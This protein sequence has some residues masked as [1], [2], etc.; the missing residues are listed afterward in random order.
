MIG[1]T[2]SHYKILEKLGEGGMGIVYKAQDTKLDRVVA[3]KFLPQQTSASE[4]DK[5]RFLQEAK[6]AAAL[7]HPNICTIHGIEEVQ[8]NAFIVM[9]FVEGRTL[10]EQTEQSPLKVKEA[11]DIAVKIAQGLTAAHEKGIVHR[12]M[13]SAN[14]M[15]TDNMDVKIMDF[16][17]A[18]IA[19]GSALLTKQG[20]TLGTIAYMSPE[21]ARGEKTDRR[22]DVWSLGV[23]LYEIVTGRLPFKGEFEQAV[24][25][26]LLNEEP[27]PVTAVRSGVPLGLERVI[28]KAMA[29]DPDSRYQHADEIIVDLKSVRSSS[30][31]STQA[32]KVSTSFNGHPPAQN[33]RWTLSPLWSGVL[34]AT[35]LLMGGGLTWLAIPKTSPRPLPVT[36]FVLPFD[37]TSPADGVTSFAISP[38]GSRLAYMTRRGSS[39]ELFIREMDKLEARPVSSVKGLTRTQL[40]FSPDSRW[41]GFFSQGKMNKL[42]LGGGAPIIICDAPS[43]SSATWGEGGSIVFHREW[44]SHLWIV[45]SEANST[46]RQLTTLK[47]E[48]GERGHLGASMLPGGTHALFTIWTGGALEDALIAA[49]EL[50]TGKHQVIV[51]GGADAHYVPS[52][53]LVYSRGATLMAVPFNLSSMKTTGETLPVMDNVRFAGDAGFSSMSISDNGTVAY[54]AGGVTYS[55]TSVG[56]FEAGKKTRDITLSGKNFG[57]PF[58]SPDGKKMGLVLFADTYHLSLYDLQKQTLT[59]LTFS[60]DN[61]RPTWLR[62]GSKIAYS[63]NLGGKYTVYTINADGSGT[64]E[65]LF[66]QEG[67]PYPVSWSPDG[68]TLAYVTTGK[69][70]KDDIWFYSREGEPKLRPF[71][72][73]SATENS[74]RISPDGRWIAYVSNES[75][76]E[77]VYVKRYPSGDGKWRISNGRGGLPRWSHDG[78]Q[79]YFSR[80]DKILAVSVSTGTDKTSSMIDIGREVDV[81]TANGLT[82]F[83]L[84]PNGKTIVVAQQGV[85]SSPD[86][87][88]MVL[89]WFEELKTKFTVK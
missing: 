46:P 71:L 62:D 7:N 32:S 81:L 33:K 27:E 58:Y 14:V 35:A 56:L 8:E 41:L 15:I 42:S 64:P 43:N 34:F 4:Q 18:K 40:F 77:A 50:A 57:D 88:H 69:E 60:A 72:Q 87:L 83:D 63:S 86:K 65:K 26:S 51:R 82:G 75:G 13:K 85:G 22:T 66:E 29:K 84:S 20:T 28:A 80:V 9:E 3:L 67:N 53:H 61:W 25:Y 11:I 19:K 21:Q 76:E 24:V 10:K 38:D 31:S 16:G 54:I 39:E 52:G 36:R 30:S 17:L 47:V 23:I 49:V 70:T 2:V 5:S 37:R 55:P 1:Q 44:G 78:R 73:S 68:R 59:Q 48:E 12:D 6:A 89:N 74:P 45:G 79:I